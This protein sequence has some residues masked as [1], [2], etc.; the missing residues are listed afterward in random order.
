MASKGEFMDITPDM[1]AYRDKEKQVTEVF[2]KEALTALGKNAGGNQGLSRP[3]FESPC[4]PRPPRKF[5]T[6]PSGTG[7]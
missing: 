3:Y 4:P 7:T 2:K 6:G 5:P 1:L